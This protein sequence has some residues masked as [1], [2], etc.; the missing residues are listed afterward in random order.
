M[1]KPQI[2]EAI[3]QMPNVERLEVIEFALRLVREDMEKPE[4]LSLTAAAEI[5][6]PYYVEGSDLTE[7]VDT[8][9]ED[10]YEYHDYA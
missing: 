7:L 2:L 8:C 5:M 6:H 10:F 1:I 3:K 9:N 4:K